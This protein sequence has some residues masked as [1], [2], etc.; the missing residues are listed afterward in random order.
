MSDKKNNAISKMSGG[1]A[2]LA[3]L[4]GIIVAANV[5]ISNLRIRVDLTDENLYT[6]SKGSREILNKLENEVTLKFYFSESSPEMPM[7]LK[8]YAD[9]VQ[10]LLKE[11]EIAGR[12]KIILEAYDTK[13]DS[14]A[15]EW[16]QRYGIE[17]QQTSLLGPAVYFGLAGVAGD[18]EEV[19]AGPHRIHAG[20]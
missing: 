18:T 2:G 10:D 20:V 19:I 1:I 17:P 7:G 11:Y 9:Q 14:D 15:E 16:A 12:G 4:L 13:P 8:T 6:L 5:I 3:L